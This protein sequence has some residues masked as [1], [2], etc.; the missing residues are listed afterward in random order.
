[1][2]A[3]VS[4]RLLNLSSADSLFYL[5]AMETEQKYVEIHQFKR[6]AIARNSRAGSDDSIKVAI[7][8]TKNID[9]CQLA[10]EAAD[11]TPV[12]MPT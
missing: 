3:F 11:K 4:A 9:I 5:L 12:C 2:P 8:T 10:I 7:L 1:M 6:A